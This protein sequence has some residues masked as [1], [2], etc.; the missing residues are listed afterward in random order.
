MRDTDWLPSA[1]AT[2]TLPR[3]TGRVWSGLQAGGGRLGGTGG[4]RSWPGWPDLAWVLLWVA[5][6]AGI[7]FGH[8]ET[9][10]FHLIWLAFALIY[11]FRIRNTRPTMLVLAAMLMT[12][13]AAIGTD[14]LRGGRPA[15][16]LTEVP[17]MA[18]M[19]WIMMWHGRR[20]LAANADR[21]RVSEEN[22]RLLATQRRFLQDASHQL[23]TPITIAL[24]HSELLARNL[25]DQQDKRDIEVIVGELNRLRILS[26]RLL[27]IAASANPDFLRPEPVEI[28]QFI[29]DVLWRWRPTADRHWLL[30]Q[31]DGAT[32]I[33][34]PD[35]LGLAVDALLE[36]AI[37][38]TTPDDIIRLAVVRDDLDGA[39]SLVVQDTGTGIPASE[40][41]HVFDR[42]ATGALPAE[43]HR[44][45]GLGLALVRAVAQGHGGRVRAQSTPGLG[46]R[47]E[48]VLPL[49]GPAV[50]LPR[51]LAAPAQTE[52]PVKP[53][54]SGLC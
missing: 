17:L 48:L 2:P 28:D 6:L 50:P 10:P 23:R 52:G 19:F 41:E 42:F 34:D 26:E 35:R 30:G 20:R 5:G 38:H 32:A 44:G 54:R 15:D 21:A 12:T 27:L 7:V 37:Q 31:L 40:L 36:N 33:A 16:E 43:G 51:A 8:W 39:V 22:E 18:A 11:S 3:L 25:V 1:A 46:S 47:F 53:C 45:T 4:W 9:V 13:A 49:A 14:M 24:G 29:P